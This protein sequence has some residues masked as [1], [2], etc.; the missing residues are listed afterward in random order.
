[1]NLAQ[2]ESKRQALKRKISTADNE[3]IEHY[4]KLILAKQREVPLTKK[5]QEKAWSCLRERENL[6]DQLNM[7]PHN[8]IGE[9]IGF[10]TTTD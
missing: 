1:M 9:P 4:K 7:L 2:E 3:V 5:E 10:N 6:L 8:N